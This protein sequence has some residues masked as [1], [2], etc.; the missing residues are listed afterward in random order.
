MK[1]LAT[2]LLLASPVL[3]Q[4][5]DEQL[6]ANAFPKD[7]V[8]PEYPEV[9]RSTFETADLNRDG[10]ALIVALYSN[11]SRARLVVLDRSGVALASSS[12][13]LKGYGGDLQFQDLDGD[14]TPEIIAPLYAGHGP[15]I[16]ESWVFAWRERRLVLVSPQLCAIVPIDLDGSGKLAVLAL[17]GRE[18]DGLTELYVWSGGH[19]VKTKTSFVYAESF[20]PH[21][22]RSFNAPPGRATLWIVHGVGE[23]GRVWLNGKEIARPSDFTLH[24]HR[25]KLQARIRK[26]NRIRV[27]LDGKESAEIWVL[28]ESLTGSTP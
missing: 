23:G 17:P 22:T 21:Q 5:S 10:T 14:G 9:R 8:D 28:V 2:L 11:G 19:L 18:K 13:P 27:E 15:Q 24:P 7:L 1:W 20:T 12:A 16:P 3:A 26:S 4:I 25:L 6:V